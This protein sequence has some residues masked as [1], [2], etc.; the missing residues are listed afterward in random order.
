MAT[1][2]V[3]QIRR[4]TRRKFSADEKIRIVLEGLRGEIPITELCR[5]QGIQPSIYYKWSKAFLDAGK[6]GLTRDTHRDATSQEVRRLKEENEALKRAVAETVLDNQRLKS[7]EGI[8]EWLPNTNW[9]SCGPLRAP[10]VPVT[11]VLAQLQIPRSSYYRWRANFRRRGLLGL[12]DRP[13]S[14]SR[15]W[16]QILPEE[17]DKM[18]EIALLYPEWSPREVSCHITDHCGFT[19]SESSVYR[20]LKVEGLIREVHQKT[21]P[22]GAEYRV[23][24]TWPNQQWQTDATYLLIKNWGWYYLISVLDDFSR[25]ILAWRLQSAMTAGDFSEVVEAACQA[26]GVG[27]MESQKRPRLV[28]DHGSALISRD[29]GYYLEAQGLGHILASPY[30]RRR[31]ERSNATIALA[32]SESICWCGKARR[33]SSGRSGR[34]S[35]TTTAGAITKH[36]AT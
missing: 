4:R 2:V 12:R 13:S 31:T 28:T 16:N 19:I 34:S 25:K 20:I 18:L 10:C 27:Q 36:S 33:S 11:Q 14:Q 30:H 23:K 6:N 22:A 1:D 5:Q 32:R 8:S 35:S 15:V 17:R 21:F 7:E 26:T 9:K 29:F 3:K 24:T